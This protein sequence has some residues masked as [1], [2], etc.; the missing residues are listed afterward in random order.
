MDSKSLGGAS[1][2]IT[3]IE[4]HSKKVRAFVLKSKNQVF[5]AFK[6]F[7]ANVEREKGRKLKYVRV[8]NGGEYIG[9][10]SCKEHGIKFEKTVP[11][12]PQDNGV[13]RE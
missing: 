5:S 7:H 8:N 2:F 9:P 1:Y 3:F 4:D 13:A 12:T 10:F 11:N 6:Q